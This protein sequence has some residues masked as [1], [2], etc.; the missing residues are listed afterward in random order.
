MFLLLRNKIT[1]DS[2]YVSTAG[3]KAHS[4]RHCYLL[5]EQR[6]ALDD[7]SVGLSYNEINIK[8][9]ENDQHKAEYVMRKEKKRTQSVLTKKMFRALGLGTIAVYY[10]LIKERSFWV[11][12]QLLVWILVYQLYYLWFGDSDLF[13]IICISFLYTSPRFLRKYT[14][15]VVPPILYNMQAYIL[16]STMTFL[17]K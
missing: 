2:L 11:F 14:F 17:S 16:R 9:L 10:G 5:V 8:A 3:Q 7:K 4:P 13:A 15:F 12:V 6:S 1:H